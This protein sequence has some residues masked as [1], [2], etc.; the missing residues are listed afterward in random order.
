MSD[1]P[2]PQRGDIWD[3]YL[4]PTVGR[5][6]GGRRPVVVLSNELLNEAPSRLCIVAPLTTR[7]RGIFAH[8]PVLPGESGL[9]TRSFILCDQ[10][11]SSSH[12]RLKRYR[13]RISSGEVD[14]AIEIVNLLM[15]PTDEAGP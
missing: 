10:V 5:E 12:E 11:R 8:P 15:E 3:A 7:D 4:D 2:V 14:R 6:Q 9:K 13:G 1:R